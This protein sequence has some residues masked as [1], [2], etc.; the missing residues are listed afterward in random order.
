MWLPDFRRRRA[1]AAL[2]GATAMI[3]LS[4]CSFSPVYGPGQRAGDQHPFNYAAPTDRLQQIV[5]SE[6]AFRLGKATTEAAPLIS[7]S[8]SASGRRLAR[9]ATDNPNIAYEIVAEGTLTATQNGEQ[10]FTDH[11][12]A[13]ASY[14]QNGQVLADRQAETE[15]KERA[16]KMLAESFRLAI[17]GH[18]AR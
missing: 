9:S 7:V 16:A 18:F 8:V 15:A 2:L 1:L 14:A 4:G 12:T 6:L 10:L 5:Y 17:L 11:R 13:R 3:A